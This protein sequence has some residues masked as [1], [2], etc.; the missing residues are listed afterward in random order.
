VNVTAIQ[1]F[2]PLPAYIEDAL[3]ASIKRFGVLVPIT[4]DQH[5][6]V[7]DG[8]HRKRIADELGITYE[9][10]VREC[11]SDEERR[12]IAFTLNADRRQI[13]AEQRRAVAI[14]LRKMKHSYRAIAGALGVDH[15]TIMDDV[16]RSTGG[17][18]PVALPANVVGLDGKVRAAEKAP[19]P[20]PLPAPKQRFKKRD[21]E[22]ATAIRNELEKD[23]GATFTTIAERVGCHGNTVTSVARELGID[24]KTRV[25]TR[26]DGKQQ[27]VGAVVT[28]RI[29]L[30]R[31]RIS[32]IEDGVMAVL[33]RYGKLLVVRQEVASLIEEMASALKSIKDALRKAER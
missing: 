5:G 17:E 22:L 33:E 18:S 4:T 20:E 2:D 21:R 27:D 11:C 31:G 23:D 3:R 26:A 32:G 15:T 25:H 16:K 28:E 19:A 9:T 10:R 30:V 1:I 24:G 7:L 6:A 12:E 29:S 14:E 8:H 13:S